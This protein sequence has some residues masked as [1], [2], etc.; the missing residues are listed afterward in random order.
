MH[1]YSL[2]NSL[3]NQ[4]TELCE[5]NQGDHVTEIVVESGPLSGVEPLLL[6]TAFSQLASGSLAENA[7][8]IIHEV[9]LKASCL[10]CQH[11]FEVSRFDFHCPEC[12]SGKTQVTQ[13]DQFQLTRISVHETQ[14]PAGVRP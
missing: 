6:Q 12:H 7:K 13:G 8:L 14:Q 1:E 3:L 11:S 9:P 5:Q 2:M 10:N 4:V